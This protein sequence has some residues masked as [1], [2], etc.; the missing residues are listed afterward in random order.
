MRKQKTRKFTSLLLILFIIFTNTQATVWASLSISAP[1]LQHTNAA[2]D[3]TCTILTSTLNGPVGMRGFEGN[4]EISCPN[5]IV[6]I[7]VQFIT[8]PSVALRLMQ[9]R[10]TPMQRIST[11]P[12]TG[13]FDEQAL[14]AHSAF[15]QQ[16][17]S[18]SMQFSS[19]R[20]MNVMEIISTHYRLFNGVFMR[21]PGHMAE[22]I[23][24]LPEV[25]AVTPNVALYTMYDLEQMHLKNYLQNEYNE[26]EYS[27]YTYDGYE[28]L[29]LYPY[30]LKEEYEENLL[31]TSFFANENFM[32]T[33]REY[34]DLDY[35]HTEMGITG[36]GVRVAVLDTGINHAH[37]EFANFLDETGRIRGWH[38]HDNNDNIDRNGH[39]TA[40]SG[41]VIGVAPGVELWMYRVMEGTMHV[42]TAIELAHADGMD[43]INMSFGTYHAFFPFHPL[44][45]IVNLAALDGIVMVSAAGNSGSEYFNLYLS[46]ADASLAITVGSGNAGGVDAHNGDTTRV[47]SSQG[48][49]FTIPGWHAYQ[50][51]PDI[52]APSGVVTA[53]LGSWYTTASGTSYAAP[54]VAG[55][56]ALLIEAFPNDTP[57]EIKARMMNTAR[58]L[59]GMQ[60][61]NVFAV[62]SGFVQPFHALTNEVI[63]T[64]QH[65]VPMD[66]NL[67]TMLILFEPATMASLS[68]GMVNLLREDSM[69]KTIPVSI[70]NTGHSA[71]TYTISHVFTRNS[72]GTANLNMSNTSITVESGATSQLNATLQIGSKAHTG[73]YGGYIYVSDGTGIVARL[74]FGAV[75][76]GGSWPAPNVVRVYNEAQLRAAVDQPLFSH[77]VVEVAADIFLTQLLDIPDFTNVTLRSADGHT[78]T[79]ENRFQYAFRGIKVIGSLTLE[80]IRLTS[81]GRANSQGVVVYGG[82]LTMLDGAVIT[83]NTASGIRLEN[84]GIVNMYG[85]EISFNGAGGVWVRGSFIGDTTFNMHG[86]RISNNTY[87]SW[88]GG[89]VELSGGVFNMYGGEISGNRNNNG[90]GVNSSHNG[91]FNMHGGKI[92]GNIANN[93]GGGIFFATGLSAVN[94]YSGGIS[95]NTATDGGGIGTSTIDN[96]RAGRLRIG[97]GV[98][99]TNNSASRSFNRL[100]ADDNVYYEFV[101]ATQWSHVFTQGFNNFDIE[102]TVGTEVRIRTLHFQLNGTPANPTN[103]A[104]VESINVISGTPIISALAFPHEPERLNYTFA[105]WYLDADFTQR[106][107][108]DITMPDADTTI[109]ALWQAQSGLPTTAVIRFYFNIPG[110]Y[111]YIEIEFEV[112]QENIGQQIP[113]HLIPT[114]PIR[115]GIVGNPG[116]AFLGW[117]EELFPDMHYINYSKRVTTAQRL[118]AIDLLSNLVIT[119]EMLDANNMLELHA[120]WVRFGDLNGD[121]VIDP[122]DRSLMQ[123]RIL[124]SLTNDGVIMQTANLNPDVDNIVDPVDR[125]LLQNHILGAPG[126]ILGHVQ[127]Q[128]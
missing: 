78:R 95:Y 48:P 88:E 36:A 3:N 20:S 71:T 94:I 58:P 92:S 97:P 121:G 103:P 2:L 80:N 21:V 19:S 1:P 81:A 74:P 50:I 7:I 96:I 116:C 29:E 56:A 38:H 125:S 40:V 77:T 63:V 59:A 55:I 9:D 4:Y 127:R 106:L 61:N 91:V 51:K 13:S 57:Y 33:V 118:A 89:G 52:I 104:Q 53:S 22:I 67:L 119:K 43:I 26:P 107:T 31:Y 66:E 8:P 117:Y 32:R 16:L 27:H 123:N 109:Y 120:S 122:V 113:P 84:A 79:I 60:P 76:R 24:A 18:I 12:H 86:G 65:Y 69:N 112:E 75:V 114:V 28:E 6:E 82:H 72:S 100:P 98:V 111:E 70:R 128:Q 64:A 62:G 68:F 90:G 101:H 93:N 54:I 45:G 39:G 23:A 14:L 126:V 110:H 42:F 115:Y 11:M 46:P 10:A 49:S 102:Y 30:Y 124:G 17:N 47:Y 73:F 37:P 34:F 44:T 15:N 5:D 41:A 25:F 87:A 35:I 99:F 83:N 108:T 85:G 105:G